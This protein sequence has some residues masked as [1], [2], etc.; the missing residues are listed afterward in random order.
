MEVAAEEA[1][2]RSTR[3]T[4]L[5]LS[6]YEKYELREPDREDAGGDE[7]RDD[8]GVFPDK[9]AMRTFGRCH[10]GTSEAGRLYRR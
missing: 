3:V 1:L 2:S 7:R 6:W 9:T 10:G 5:L 8:R 4:A